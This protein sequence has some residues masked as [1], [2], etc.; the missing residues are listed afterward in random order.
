MRRWFV[1]FVSLVLLA[2][3]CE[4]EQGS[5][6]LENRTDDHLLWVQ[7]VPERLDIYLQNNSGWA[8]IA[9]NATLV[10]DSSF[11]ANPPDWC[12]EPAIVNYLLRPVDQRPLRVTSPVD[13]SLA[14]F[15]IVFERGPGHCWGDRDAS[16]IFEG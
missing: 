13:V 6:T 15:D 12:D 16:W 3:S 11:G 9:P 10:R 8:T 1:V 2:A 14:D 7:A 4:A 5:V